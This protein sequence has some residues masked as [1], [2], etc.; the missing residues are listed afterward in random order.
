MD[1]LDLEH[2]G[3]SHI[4]VIHQVNNYVIWGNIFMRRYRTMLDR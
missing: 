4:L 3:T 1:V 2:I